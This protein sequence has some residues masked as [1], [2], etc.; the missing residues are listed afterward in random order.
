MAIFRKV[1]TSF[2]SDTFISD[3]DREKKLF[4]LYLLT[5]EKTTQCGIYEISKKQIAFDLGYSIDTVC[6][7][8]AYFI[9]LG[10]I[11]YN[12]P[13]KEMAIGNWLK[14]NGSTSPKVKTCIDKEFGK[15]K[16]TVLIQYI[17]SMD[18]H[19]QEEE[20]EE[21]EEE[22]EQKNQIFYKVAGHLKLTEDEYLKLQALGYSDIEI[23]IKLEAIENSTKN[24][25]YKSY[26]L[27]AK[28]WLIKD[29]GIRV[30]PTLK[31]VE[32]VF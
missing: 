11:R 16:D 1:H 31:E 24:K 15:V 14:Y 18:T 13:T 22:R 12:E 9:K 4:Y 20:E 7:L 3:L 2:W 17:Y 27:T 19:P 21:Q 8:L 30:K 29:Y 6:K 26:F 25:N 10:K 5:N 28:N 32:F 23:N